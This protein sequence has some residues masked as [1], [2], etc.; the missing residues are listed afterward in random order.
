M[1]KK[2]IIIL[3]LILLIGSGLFIWIYSNSRCGQF[4][5]IHSYAW[6]GG[7]QKCSNAGCNILKVKEVDNPK[8]VD[9]ERFYYLCLP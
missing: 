9:D 3:A 2:K 6:G 5:G 1:E 8:L 4:F 7:S